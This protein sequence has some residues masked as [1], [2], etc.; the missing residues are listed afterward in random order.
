MPKFELSA[1]QQAIVDTDAR[2]VLVLAGPGAG[3]TATMVARGENLLASRRV[4]DGSILF[5]TFTVK[6]AQE[7]E[8]R[9][10]GDIVSGTFH[11]F[12][13]RLLQEYGDRITWGDG[14]ILQPPFTVLDET[15]QL[16][17]MEEV[18]KDLRWKMSAKKLV[19]FYNMGEQPGKEPG[20]PSGMTEG[21]LATVLSEYEQRKV[22]G[23]SVDF[24]GLVTVLMRILLTDPDFLISTRNRFQAIFVDEG[25]D[26]DP[27]QM[28]LVRLL[29]GD[30]TY[31]TVVGDT[32]Q[33]LYSWRL[34]DP[35]LLLGRRVPVLGLPKEVQ[36]YDTVALHGWG[37]MQDPMEWEK[38][39]LGDN[40][41]SG[42]SIVE[43]SRRLIQKNQDRHDIPLKPMLSHS[44]W[45]LDYPYPYGT[46]DAAILK[47]V[48]NEKER[49]GSLAFLTRTNFMAKEIARILREDGRW[50]HYL[51]GAESDMWED[52]L[53]KRLLY[54]MRICSNKFDRW[55]ALRLIHMLHGQM[56]DLAIA[57]IRESA[58]VRGSDVLTAAI[59]HD[60]DLEVKLAGIRH[61]QAMPDEPGKIIAA[62]ECA[63]TIMPWTPIH[64]RIEKY[65]TAWAKA[66]K[67]LA[68]FLFF[69]SYHKETFRESKE[70]EAGTIWIS[71]VHKAKGKE[72]DTVVI[73]GCEPGEFPP[74]RS[75]NPEEERRTFYV[76]ITRP[77]ERL[78]FAHSDRRLKF[79]REK[80]AGRSP[81]VDEGWPAG[82]AHLE[83]QLPDVE[84]FDEPSL[85]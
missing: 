76:A 83:V 36:A 9:F 80:P 24:R 27:L 33:T 49:G 59:E 1:A 41:R 11:A 65:A 10:T 37:S 32:D 40:F 74:R 2:R 64:E 34:A 14:N 68:A 70:L 43:G 22:D 29:I 63:K 12:C 18:L 66:G 47:L 62:L 56:S 45:I 50:P 77:R 35:G 7:I 85:F 75:D 52:V 79:G 69:V 51:V 5:L 25:Q 81:Y 4:E 26:T 6:A 21:G 16:A 8:E 78:I 3:K 61:V 60:P 54:V 53:A 31:V 55:T 44:G 57:T 73:A 20:L 71:T 42:I 39:F 46:E 19:E 23:N 38:H 28:V 67:R 72:W 84:V 48:E 15:D 17:L 13:F 30:E 82:I 58:S